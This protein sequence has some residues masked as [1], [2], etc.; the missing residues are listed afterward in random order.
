MSPCGG[1]T[2]RHEIEIETGNDIEYERIH[3]DF[4]LLDD[5]VHQVIHVME[6]YDAPMRGQSFAMVKNMFV[7]VESA[8]GER[9]STHPVDAAG[10]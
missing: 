4:H 1:I 5:R 3:V 10:L 9:L 7:H 2:H 6:L 8:T